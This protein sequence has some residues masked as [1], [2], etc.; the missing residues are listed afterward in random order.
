MQNTIPTISIQ[1]NLKENQFH[2]N[3]SF[4][5][6]IHMDYFPITEN[7]EHNLYVPLHWHPEVELHY[8]IQ[9]TVQIRVELTE[10]ILHPGEVLW[11]NAKQLHNCRPIGSETAISHTIIFDPAFI[12]GTESS[13]LFRKYIHPLLGNPSFPA[14]FIRPHDPEQQVL[15]DILYKCGV[16]QQEKPETWEL[17]VL[18]YLS[19][20]WGLLWKMSQRPELAVPPSKKISRDRKTLDTILDYIHTNFNKK[21]TLQDLAF[22]ASISAGECGRL[23]KRLLHQTPMNYLMSYRIDQSIPLLVNTEATIT[24]IAL[25]V[26]FSGASYYTEIFHRIMGVTPSEY[27]NLILGD[28][29]G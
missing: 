25:Q 4:P 6:D 22:A 11:I 27:R 13:I 3:Y 17:Q 20:A 7:E 2:G 28:I 21:I 24:E 26:G 14:L 18:S 29:P 1:K 9:G 10:Y 19:N 12:Y 16:L 5:V 15:L 23:C 8:Q